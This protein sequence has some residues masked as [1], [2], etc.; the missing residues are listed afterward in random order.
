MK[1]AFDASPDIKDVISKI[2]RT[3]DIKFSPDNKRLAVIS[4]LDNQI[5]LFSIRIDSTSAKPAISILSFSRLLSTSLNHPHGVSFLDDDHIIVCN[6]DSGVCIF[7]IPSADEDWSQTDTKPLEIINGKGMLFAKVKTPGSVASYQIAEN[8]YRAL[9]C[10]NDWHM[11]TSHL[12]RIGN[13]IEITNE[14]VLIENGLNVPDGIDISADHEYIAISNHVFGEI[15]IYKNSSELNRTTPPIAKLCGIVC[16]HGVR[17]SK[18]GKW[19]FVADAANQFLFAYEKTPGG[20]RGI[21]NPD[22]TIRVLDDHSFYAG[23]Y[24]SREGGIKGIDIDTSN[25]V[26]FT[27]QRYNAISCYDMNAVLAA[28]DEVNRDEMLELCQHRD[29]SFEKPG[30]Q[31]LLKQ[32][33]TIKSRAKYALINGFGRTWRRYKRALY[34]RTVMACLG[35]KNKYSNEM[36]LDPSGPVVSLTT[37]GPRLELVF[38]AIES[39]CMGTRKPSRIILW[40]E[41]EDSFSTLSETLQRLKSR[42]LE[43]HLSE[44]YGP[45]TKYYPY[46]DS[47]H[48]FHQP[49]VTADDDILYPRRWLEELI[50][51]YESDP[52]VI[53]CQRARRIGLTAKR[54][55]PYNEW[56]LCAD[57]KSSHRNFITGVA[58]VI[59]PPYFLQYLKNQGKE[60]VQSCPEA[61]DIWLTVNALRSGFKIA[62]VKDVPANLWKIRGS[63]KHSLYAT[64]VVSG[65]NQPQLLATFTESDLAN[66]RANE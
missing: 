53:H 64:N 58:G 50:Q 63:Q 35:F 9:V 46:I 44:A 33:W 20:W 28:N 11:V 1:I 19:V 13:T 38:Y 6:R 62:Q 7:R 24:D 25:S 52:A 39:I 59:Y 41:D 21:Q 30:K 34:V 2:G 27:T 31:R 5:Y 47:E 23:R 4:Y 32:Q 51:A 18:D 8:C 26:L 42:G 3:E 43:I 12:I 29:L 54:L 65:G 36:L 16:P 14:G 22:K 10:N 57:K 40:I 37:H 56:K 55:E 15:D 60:F 48:D 49:L 66:L 45:H 17:F 61:D